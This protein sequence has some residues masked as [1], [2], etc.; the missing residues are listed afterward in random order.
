MI[1]IVKFSKPGCQPC[2]AQDIILQQLRNEVQF[3]LETV[4]VLEIDRAIL[5]EKKISSVPYLEIYQNDKLLYSDAGM[6]GK[7]K[8]LGILRNARI[9]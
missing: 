1:K 9:D 2:V 8:I 7:E 6:I 4:N 5:D 3:V